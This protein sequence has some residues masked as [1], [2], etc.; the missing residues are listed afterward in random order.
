MQ[1][2]LIGPEPSA[3]LPWLLTHSTTHAACAA[4]SPMPR[5]PLP[6]V[7]A[8]MAMLLT[9]VVSASVAL[10]HA[11]PLVVAAKKVLALYAEFTLTHCA[12]PF[13]P[14]KPAV[15]KLSSLSL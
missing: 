6:Q 9:Q 12:S 13:S 1:A 4:S 10:W 8:T 5:Q 2:L 7:P 15:F 3:K 11:P 14:P